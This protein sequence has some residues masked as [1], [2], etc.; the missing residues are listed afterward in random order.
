MTNGSI[1]NSNGFNALVLALTL[2]FFT[3][4]CTTT[5]EQDGKADKSITDVAASKP[6]FET[7]TSLVETAGLTETL[8]VNGPFTVF[9][10]TDAA[11]AQVPQEALDAILA[12][13]GEL[14]RVLT[15]HVVEGKLTAADIVTMS[16]LTTLSGETLDVEV[17]GPQV[18][19]GGAIVADADI[20][21]GNG[22]I[23]AINGVLLPPATGTRPITPTPITDE[24]NIV[25]VASDAGSFST[26]VAAVEAAGLVDALTGAGPFTVF[27][28]TDAAFEALP[29]GTVDAL[30]ADPAALAEILKYHV[31]AGAL[32]ADVV[33]IT[34]ALTT[35]Q[36]DA[37]D[38][39]VQDGAVFINNAKIVTTDIAASNGVIHVIDA[40]LLPLAEPPATSNTLIEVAAQAGS[41]STLLT[42]VEAAGLTDTLS[43]PGPFTVFAPTDAAFSALPQ[44]A[45]GGLLNDTEALTD[46]LLYHVIGTQ[47]SS[48]AVVAASALNTLQGT[49]VNVGNSGGKVTINGATVIITD[50]QADNGTIHVIDAVLLPS[51]DGGETV[52][53]PVQPALGNIIEKAQ[54]ND[55]LGTLLTA[56]QAAGLTETLK[57]DG[58]FTL[59]AP[60]DSAFAA[61]PSGT[62]GA[63]LANP[64]ALTDVL[65]YHV[66]AGQLFSD[67]LQGLDELATLQGAKAPLG[68]F[69]PVLT[70]DGAVFTV[71]DIEASNGV[72][73]VI[74]AVL[75][76]PTPGTIA[77]VATEA[78]SFNTLLTAAG[79]AGIAGVLA[80][81]AQELTVF[82]PT[83]AAFAALP[84][85]TIDALLADTETLKAILLYHV[86]PGKVKADQVV[87]SSL[88]ATL[89]GSDVKVTLENGNVFINDSQIITT[90]IKASNGVIH[91]IDAVLTPPASIGKTLIGHPQLFS[92]LVTA[93]Q[94]AGLFDALNAPG[95]LTVFAPTNDAFDA[96]P[97]GVIK[98]LFA[99][100]TALATILG[101]HAVAGKFAAAD[102]VANT[103]F[104]TLTEETINIEVSGG[105]VYVNDAQVIVTDIP[106]SNGVIHVIDTVLLPPSN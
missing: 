9:A 79:A 104:T 81:P 25:E 98:G 94:V 48:D 35:L 64:E 53:P 1:T 83:D 106:A 86:L 6:G 88:L 29:A 84:A 15:Y 36:G 100:P 7:F 12:K 34:S 27:A 5:F 20:L 78:G 52:E 38:V 42:A 80:D 60:T 59:F 37:I 28:P 46:V 75:L 101:Y 77:E 103:E 40:V 85:G 19:V 51:D 68:N 56:V 99:N 47:L 90:D 41:F 66:A 76:P 26:L 69:G 18:R 39:T 63:L 24:M 45:L 89:Q 74:N 2:T 21:A 30:L 102:V 92:T 105:N 87:A 11:F 13:D 54:G 55:H 16:S 22:V 8:D 71:T 33:S 3:L 93:T 50:I 58:P 73:H 57:G 82:A 4:G 49:A 23:H 61:L 62:L 44:G 32:K 70:I 10:P 65:L 95:Q 91:V 72:I 67:D 14:A 17:N 96:L 97:K 31:V 43:G